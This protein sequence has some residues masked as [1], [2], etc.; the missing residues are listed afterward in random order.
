LG[1]GFGDDREDFN[2][3]FRNVIKHP[4]VVNSQTIL[5]LT[6]APE[7]LDATPADLRRFMAQMA[8]ESISHSAPDVT[9]KTAHRLD[10]AR[11]QDDIEP[12]SG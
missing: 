7:P 5:R 8:L 9:W 6:D 4:N 1:L 12:H 11:R 3:F 10:G 2:C